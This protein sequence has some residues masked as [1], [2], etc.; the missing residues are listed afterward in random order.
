MSWVD[1][2]PCLAPEQPWYVFFLSA[3]VDSRVKVAQSCRKISSQ[4]REISLW[5]VSCPKHASEEISK[6]LQ[7]PFPTECCGNKQKLTSLRWIGRLRLGMWLR[8]H[9]ELGKSARLK[10]LQDQSPTDCCGANISLHRFVQFGGCD[11]GWC[12][13][14]VHPSC[15]ATCLFPACCLWRHW[16][17]SW[18]ASIWIQR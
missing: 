17:A 4:T 11:L 12:R 10:T 7:V 16:W 18:Q 6:T 9:A 5:A 8:K 13:Q 3:K 2:S 1:K 15:G 14:S